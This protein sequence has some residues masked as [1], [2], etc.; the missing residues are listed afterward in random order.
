MGEIIK[1]NFHLFSLDFSLPCTYC[2]QTP[3]GFIFHIYAESKHF[4]PSP[5]QCS[6]LSHHYLSYGSQFILTLLP[7]SEFC[8]V[9]DHWPSCTTD[10][11]VHDMLGNNFTG[12]EL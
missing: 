9:P 6:D 10:S 12:M 7:F 5:L 4:L 11:Q 8:S 2:I 3:F 1:K